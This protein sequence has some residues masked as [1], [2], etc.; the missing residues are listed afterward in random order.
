M[1]TVRV[2]C[3]SKA[4]WQPSPGTEEAS[5]KSLLGAV[6]GTPLLNLESHNITTINCQDC[7]HTESVARD[8][9]SVAGE[10]KQGELSAL[11]SYDLE[12]STL[13]KEPGSQVQV[14]S[15]LLHYHSA[16]AVHLLP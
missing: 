5:D 11:S 13:N 14:D 3:W 12:P 10:Q 15:T 7:Q 6:T 2:G 9:T 8:D 16:S 1:L 4:P